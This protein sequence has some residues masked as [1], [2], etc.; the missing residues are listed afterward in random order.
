MANNNLIVSHGVVNVESLK[1]HSN[2]ILDMQVAKNKDYGNSIEQGVN[3]RGWMYLMIQLENKLNRFEQLITNNP[4]VVQEAIHDTLDDI[5]G[6]ALHGT[7]IAHGKIE[8]PVAEEFV[9]VAPRKPRLKSKVDLLTLL[10]DLKSHFDK[11]VASYSEMYHML[12][13]LTKVI[14]IHFPDVSISE[15]SDEKVR[16]RSNETNIRI[17]L[18]SEFNDS[19]RKQYN[20]GHED[21]YKAGTRDEMNHMKEK[22]KREELAGEAPTTSGLINGINVR[23]AV[24]F[25]HTKAALEFFKKYVLPQG[26]LIVHNDATF[27]CYENK[28]WLVK[29][30]KEG[31]FAPLNNSKV[32]IPYSNIPTIA[33]I[34]ESYFDEVE[35]DENLAALRKAVD[36]SKELLSKLYSEGSLSISEI[37]GLLSNFNE[38][39]YKAT[40]EID[41]SC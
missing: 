3:K 9:P 8:V 1:Y 32:I 20:T 30:D 5:V 36:A 33:T 16:V 13:D 29:T 24:K 17:M 19:L 39:I 34:C 18:E 41:F 40:E 7:T 25:T 4:A 14:K 28:L 35:V 27:M 15:R 11:N 38:K 37:D 23:N 12:S 22:R 10:D 6:Y 2:R 21:G 26:K 31:I